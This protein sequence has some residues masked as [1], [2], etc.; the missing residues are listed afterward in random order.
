MPS[1]YWLTVNI[2]I[3]LFRLILRFS[4][5]GLPPVSSFRVATFWRKRKS[6][7]VQRQSIRLKLSLLVPP[8]F[9]V[10]VARLLIGPFKSRGTSILFP[11]LSCRGR[12]P[13]LTLLF[14]KFAMLLSFSPFSS[15]VSVKSNTFYF[16]LRAR[17]TVFS[18]FLI[19]P[20]VYLVHLLLVILMVLAVLL[21][22]L[23]SRSAPSFL[24]RRRL[25]F[26]VARFLVL[27]VLPAQIPRRKAALHVVTPSFSGRFFPITRCPC[28]LIMVAFDLVRFLFIL[29]V[30]RLKFHFLETKFR[31]MLLLFRE[32]RPF[33][34]RSLRG[35]NPVRRT[36]SQ[37]RA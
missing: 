20:R 5:T 12:V 7:R 23:P 24:V 21:L 29:I 28:R 27:V 15:R 2:L 19:V 3:L 14:L 17:V 32:I 10:G 35:S 33:R 9:T 4:V 16:L 13:V 36:S 22:T 37:D 18:R 11:A 8:V 31:L 6:F 26:R 25:P 1:P 30:L 34:G